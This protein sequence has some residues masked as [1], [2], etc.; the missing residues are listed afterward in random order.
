MYKY[1]TYTFGA[2]GARSPPV[3]ANMNPVNM[4]LRRPNLTYSGPESIEAIRLNGYAQKRMY[5]DIRR[6]IA[7]SIWKFFESSNKKTST[8]K[9]YDENVKFVKKTMNMLSKVQ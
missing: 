7:G 5:A 1:I 3:I 8:K 9:Q 6:A 4:R 2:N